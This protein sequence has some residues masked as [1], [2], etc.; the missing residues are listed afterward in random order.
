MTERNNP[1]TSHL[2][3]CSTLDIIELISE[4]DKTVAE[5][6]AK[7]RA[8]IAKAVDL[9]VERLS[10]WGRL[11]FVGAGTSGRLGVMEA[12][13]CPPTFGTH[14]HM[15]EGIIAGGKKA[16]W[17]SIEGAED[18]GV[19][20]Q[21]ML[22]KLKLNKKDVVVGIAASATTPFVRGALSYAKRKRSARVLVSCNPVN[23]SLAD[24]TISLP[25]GP[26]AVVGSTRMKAGTATKMVLNM[27]TTASM[28]RL[29]KTYGNLMVEVRP[30]SQKLKDRAVR[31]AVQILGI[32]S[33]KA[34]SLLVRSNWDIKTAVVMEKKKLSYKEAKELL[35]KYNGFL[36]E[37]LK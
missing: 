21:K 30:N 8:N 9:I 1:R 3:E 12:A 6:V 27:L 14:P 11:F 15:I 20:A 35:S 5:E 37:A 25:V 22:A 19:D 23:S 28:V 31:I 29:G 7:E 24:V 4:E 32:G 26:E 18:S 36:R 17:R 34:E 10:R 13:E 33:R 16:L 2:D